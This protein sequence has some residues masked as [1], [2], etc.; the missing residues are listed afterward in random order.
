MK[1]LK[2]Q[3]KTYQE[4][5]DSPERRRIETE[6]GKLENKERY[7]DKL[8][9]LEALKDGKII[10]VLHKCF[11]RAREAAQLAL[12]AFAGVRF[13]GLL[14]SLEA[15]P[16]VKSVLKTYFCEAKSKKQVEVIRD[17]L[18]KTAHGL[19]GAVALSDC[20]GRERAGGLLAEGI[21][22]LKK[23][24]MA[25]M[26]EEADSLDELYK[27]KKRGKSAR[28]AAKLDDQLYID[29]Q[30][31]M[32]KYLLSGDTGSI[33]VEFSYIGT[34]SIDAM[35]RI[36][37]HEATHKFAATVDFGYADKDTIAKLDA[38]KAILNA[39]SYAY[40]G[41]SFLKNK[42]V[43]PKELTSERPPAIEEAGLDGLLDLEKDLVPE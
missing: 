39:D 41:I 26:N 42:L 16:L 33:H 23:K 5:E 24:S 1:E 38:D 11:M 14:S 15:A 34:Y 17:T 43:T 13:T 40:A 36:M 20:A 7:K 12:E 10:L 27:K 29:Q 4:K 30:Y 18:Q 31:L 25:E 3:W 6:L 32:R 35:A 22:P 37:L 2:E 8:V 19:A 9:D 21:V 28:K